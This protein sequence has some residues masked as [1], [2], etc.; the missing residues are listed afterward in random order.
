MRRP[1]ARH[2]NGELAILKRM[3]NLAIQAGKLQHTAHFEMLRE[4]NVRVGF[5]ERDQY[6][7]N[8]RHLPVRHAADRDVPV[9]HRLAHQQRGAA[10]PVATRGPHDRGSPAGPR[11]DEERRPG[12][13]AD[14]RAAPAARPPINSFLQISL[15]VVE[16]R[17]TDWCADR[18]GRLCF[19]PG[20][21]Q[22]VVAFGWR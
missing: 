15:R 8:L 9:R 10:V 1:V 16:W 19:S 4:D 21:R 17:P 11:H 12:V 14:R 7:A 3:F 2:G 18:S 6:E 13:L 20:W 5:F 22:F